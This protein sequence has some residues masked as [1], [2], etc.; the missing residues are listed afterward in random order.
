MCVRKP[1]IVTCGIDK[2][3]R[4]W[5]YLEHTLEGMKYFTEEPYSVAFHPSGLHILVGFNDK[6]RLM[7]L[8]IEDIR[9]FKEF[10]VK[11]CRECQ[12]SHGGQYFAAINGPTIQIYNTYSCEPMAS[13]R[14]N[15]KVKSIFWLSDDS[16]IVSAAMD[17]TV[18]EWDLKEE[19]ALQVSSFV[20]V[21]FFL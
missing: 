15:G 19:K 21:Y 7:N 17:G 14:S 12:F 6:L 13:F 16:G 11:A 20:K 10:P 18:C 4:L 9:P 1:L 5:N 2:S 8:L 3:V